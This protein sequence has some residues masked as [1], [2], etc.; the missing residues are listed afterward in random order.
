MISGLTGSFFS[1]LLFLVG[2]QANIVGIKTIEDVYTILGGWLAVYFMLGIL[3]VIV[4]GNHN[5]NKKSA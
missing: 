3:L 4:L 5:P 1:A 2:L